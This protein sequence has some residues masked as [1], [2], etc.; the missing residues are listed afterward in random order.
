MD[1]RKGT[2]FDSDSALMWDAADEIERLRAVLQKIAAMDE[3]C[4]TDF[5][6]VKGWAHQRIARAALAKG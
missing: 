4:V 2:M 3:I 5:D 1:L 6:N